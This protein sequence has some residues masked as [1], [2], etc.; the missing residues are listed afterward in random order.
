MFDK[1]LK[2][3]KRHIGRNFMDITMNMKAKVQKPLMIKI[4]KLRLR[5]SG[6]S[7]NN[8]YKLRLASIVR[9]VLETGGQLLSI[10]V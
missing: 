2:K 1:H 9:R 8:Y 3:A 6:N 5:N 10:S 4:I 7:F